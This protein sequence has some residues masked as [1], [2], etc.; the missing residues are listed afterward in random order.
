MKTIKIYDEVTSIGNQDFN[1]CYN[2]KDV[3]VYHTSPLDIDQNTFDNDI[4]Y[5]AVL[6]VPEGC[7]EI[8]KKATN[9][10]NSFKQI[11]DDVKLKY[12]IYYVS[13]FG[14]Y[15][16]YEEYAREE[17]AINS[18]V[19]PIESP[20]K[21]GYTFIGWE[22]IP[23]IMPE[24]EVTVYGHFQ[25]NSYTIT[26]KVD[27]EVY[28]TASIAYGTELTAEAEPTK[29]GYVFSGWSGIP[30]T[31]PAHDV[32][33]TGSFTI[34]ISTLTY[35]VDGEEYK[36]SSI[37]Y[38]TELT[39]EAEPTKEG[40]TFSGWSE[41][42]STM[43]AHDVVVTGSF[44]VNSYTLIY[45]VDGEEYNTST[46]DYGTELTAETNPTMEGYTFSGWSE[47]P[48]TMPAKDV[49]VT[50]TF[51][52]NS[53]MATFKYGDVETT[54]IVEYGAEIPVPES[55]ASERY[56]LVEWLDV[57]ETMP[58]HDI[59][60]Y[61]IFIDGVKAVQ[62]NTQDTEYYQLNGMKRNTLQRGINIL[63]MSDGT[64]RKVQKINIS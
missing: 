47:I 31:M 28:K 15:P 17:V 13:V 8:Y 56:T 41:I 58:A 23:E 59:T 5:S 52:V 22:G 1:G 37:A 43:P 24:H 27:G 61:A 54:E 21:E 11:I 35:M 60:I 4:K 36:T 7:T 32:V 49:V 2:V 6:H 45:M 30:R 44:A 38:G 39:L 10:S 18:V 40:Y 19:P 25:V 57:P 46:I 9:W 42:P 29:E 62:S 64:T 20:M 14:S 53:Y 63:R 48:A 16:S 3:Y 50:G 51:A 33:V 12:T 34:N 26:Y 55:L